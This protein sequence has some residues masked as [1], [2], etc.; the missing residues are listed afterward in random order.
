MKPEKIKSHLDTTLE[1]TLL[2]IITVLVAVVLWQVFSR[3]VMQSPSTFTDEVARI[4]LIWLA[5]LGAA[6]VTGQR[7]HLAI[8]LLTDKMQAKGS[9]TLQ[10]SILFIIAM[11]AFLVMIV[12]GI[13]LVYVTLKLGQQST[14]LQV[15]MGYVYIAIPL[16]GVFMVVYSLCDVVSPQNQIEEER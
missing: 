16:S 5:L 6:W 13:N 11:F 1:Y 3:Y 12:G 10:R 9:F 15:P 2:F 4:L 14:V 8:D 7:A